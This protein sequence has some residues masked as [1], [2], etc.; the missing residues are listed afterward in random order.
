MTTLH[1][2]GLVSHVQSYTIKVLHLGRLGLLGHL[3]P[4]LDLYTPQEWWGGVYIPSTRSVVC[5]SAYGVYGV[6]V[7]LPV[8]SM[9]QHLGCKIQSAQFV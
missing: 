3:Y 7:S 2:L 8:Q 9:E 4:S 6:E 5:R 1:L